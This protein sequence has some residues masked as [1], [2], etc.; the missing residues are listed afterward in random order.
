MR[1]AAL[2]HNSINALALYCGVHFK[3]PIK[4]AASNDTRRRNYTECMETTSERTT[5]TRACR[6]F[7]ARDKNNHGK[8]KLPDKAHVCTY[9]HPLKAVA[10]LDMCAITKAYLEILSQVPNI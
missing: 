10:I 3:R 9:H 1:K 2:T 8:P 5:I 6:S 4:S 7:K